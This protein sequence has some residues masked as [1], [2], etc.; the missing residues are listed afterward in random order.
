MLKECIDNRVKEDVLKNGF[1]KCGLYPWDANSV[2]YT[3]L[4]KTFEPS[5]SPLNSTTNDSS[6][7]EA[8]KQIVSIKISTNLEIGVI[9]LE[10]YIGPEELGRFKQS[11]N[12]QGTIE[13]AS[14]F[15]VRKRI[16][17]ELKEPVPST[18]RHQEEKKSL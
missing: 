17:N 6:D 5:L 15:E 18:P 8:H 10:N 14:L 13:D 16:K 4:T 11:E 1:R 3:K 12:W 7:T 9:C 2:D